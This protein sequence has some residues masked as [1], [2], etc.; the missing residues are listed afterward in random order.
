M[1][2]ADQVDRGDQ[3]RDGSAQF[4]EPIEAAEGVGRGQSRGPADDPAHH[5]IDRVR[6]ARQ[7]RFHHRMPL[8]DP[9]TGIEHLGDRVEGREVGLDQ[10]RPL[11]ASARASGLEGGRLRRVA[12]KPSR[13]AVGH[14]RPRGAAAARPAVPRQRAAN[15]PRRRRTARPRGRPRRR[16]PRSARRPTPRRV[17]GRPARRPA[18]RSRR[19]SASARRCC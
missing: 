12:E 15:T 1:G 14:G 19:G 3:R 16:P 17:S 18:S 4:L 13:G 6:V 9:G 10:P 5:R 11:A 2:D 7:Q 8:G